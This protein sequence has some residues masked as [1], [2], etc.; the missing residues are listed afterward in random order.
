LIGPLG[1]LACALGGLALSRRLE[2]DARPPRLGQADGDRLFGRLGAVLAF[3]DVLHLLANELAGRRRRLLSLAEVLLGALQRLLLWHG[4]LLGR[5]D[6]GSRP[7]ALR[8]SPLARSSTRRWAGV[9]PL[10]A[11]LM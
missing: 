3:A 11:R 9:N 2:R 7:K 5:R 10:P 6:A 8:S 4:H 1:R